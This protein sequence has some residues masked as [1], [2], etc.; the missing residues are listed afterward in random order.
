M[1]AVSFMA[2]ALAALSSQAQ[3]FPADSSWVPL[4]CGAAVM[5]D[6]YQDESGALGERDLI[7]D[8]NA[9]TGYRAA[10][11]QYLFLRMRL[12]QDPIPG[13]NPRPYAWGLLLDTDGNLQTYEVLLLANG[14]GG[15]VVLYRN[16][17]TT[18]LNDPTDPPDEP[19]VKTYPLSSHARSVRA[20]GSSYGGDADY[21]LDFA[22][23][24]QDLQSVGISTSTPVTAWAAT[25]STATTLNGDF[26][27][28]NDALG[29][30]TLSGNDPGATVLDPRVDTDRDGYSDAAERAAGTNPNDPASHPSGSP[31]AIQLAGGGGC[32]V[33]GDAHL[34]AWVLAAWAG[35]A[36]RRRPTCRG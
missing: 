18:S 9:A 11:T 35:T 29:A 31:D 30:P 8:A 2:A 10:D 19:P 12:D 27:C 20:T 26:A 1:Y 21:F 5:T 16:T 36:R 4:H 33:A 22:V 13:G 23:P 24:W 28:F 17:Q 32:G 7:G 34:L 25:S 14:N 6:L 15:T 3:S